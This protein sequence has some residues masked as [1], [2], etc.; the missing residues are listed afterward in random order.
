IRSN[1]WQSSRAGLV[2]VAH[3][4]V[5]QVR[6][7]SA[8]AEAPDTATAKHEPEDCIAPSRGVRHSRSLSLLLSAIARAS[9]D[10][11]TETLPQWPTPEYAA[12]QEPGGARDAIERILARR[13]KALGVSV[14][15]RGTAGTRLRSGDDARHATL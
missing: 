5:P 12:V 13:P 9:H 6:T 8:F 3:R 15:L 4:R 1:D 7:S 2:L 14:D 11:P 10:Q